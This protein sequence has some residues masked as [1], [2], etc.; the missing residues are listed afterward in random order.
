MSIYQYLTPDYQDKVMDRWAPVLGVGKEIGDD[1]VKL[2]TALVLENTQRE[3][4]Q[5][6]LVSESYNAAQGGSFGANGT[7]G[8]AGGGTFGTYANDQY[9]TN[10]DARMPTVVIPTV[11]RIFPELLAHQ[12]CG[13]QPMNGPVGFAFALR[14]RYGVNSKGGTNGAAEDVEL[15]YNNIDSSFTGVS[16]NAATAMNASTTLSG[17]W[18]AYAG[19]TGVTGQYGQNVYSNDGM[20]ERLGASEWWN[21]GEDMPMVKFSL[22]KAT[23]EAKSRKLASHWSLELAEDMMNMHGIDVDAE[24]VN[25]MS[26][27]IAAEMDRQLLTEMVKSALQGGKYSNWSPLSADGRNQLERIGTFYTHILDKANT[28]A[29]TTRR[30]PASFAI[31]SPKVTA[32]LER[33]GDFQFDKVGNVNVNTGSVGIA[34][35]GTLRSGAITVYRD[36]FAN[37][38]YALLGYK[39]P[40]P[41]DS[42]IILCPYIPVQ[43]MRA[44]GP[45]NFSPRIGVRTRYGILGHL[46]NDAGQYYHFVNVQ[47]LTNVGL[48]G[49][50]SDSRIFTY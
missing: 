24:M 7:P 42:G 12:V 41:Y 32:L 37:S 28:I 40:T 50:N 45:D 3:F 21:I 39:G 18:Q 44:I 9:G 20:G 34:K 5:S 30:G 23:V 2:A 15:G 35:V 22:E 36:T 10:A 25:I 14:A 47:H 8:V 19:T 31:A 6:R 29:I 11:R 26:Y 16:G 33:V 4:D 43:L 38:N 48:L 46:F 49:N 1:S 17:L 27:E 13:V